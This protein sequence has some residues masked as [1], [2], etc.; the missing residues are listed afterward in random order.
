VKNQKF[1]KKTSNDERQ[2]I[3]GFQEHVGDKKFPEKL[4]LL[5]SSLNTIPTSSSEYERGFSQINPTM[6]PSQYYLFI[7][8]IAEL[9]FIKLVSHSVSLNT[10]CSVMADLWATFCSSYIQ[11]AMSLRQQSH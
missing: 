7:N 4:L 11:Q 5:R 10:V 1:V 3:C 2:M 6:T 9:L 8:T